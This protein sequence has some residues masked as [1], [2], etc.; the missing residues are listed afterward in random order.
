MIDKEL[1][2]MFKCHEYLQNLDA[3]AR[4]RVF[5]YLLD[6]YGLVNNSSDFP[7][8]RSQISNSVSESV[9]VEDV[10]NVENIST[11]TKVKAP[12]AKP[13]KGKPSSQQSY[14]LLVG[15]NLIPKDK[16]SLKEY[17][18]SF[19][20]KSNFEYNIVILS[21]LVNVLKEVNIGTNHFY[22]C[23]KHLNLKIPSLKQSL[24]D[25]KNRK[26]WID[27]SNIENIQI[28]IAGEN[29]IDHEIDRK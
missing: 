29:F 1:E 4:M 14:T 22:T 25:T 21:Y 16:K 3:E 26:G 27:T 28:T 8:T 12:V 24:F 7:D 15:L 9:I 23:Y 11:M 17:F 19:I 13:K 20:T 5:K 2:A 6:R 10:Q 18:A